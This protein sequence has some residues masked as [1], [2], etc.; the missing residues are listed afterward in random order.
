[1]YLCWVLPVKWTNLSFRRFKDNAARLQLFALAY[2][3]ANF[4]GINRWCR[5]RGPAEGHLGKIGLKSLL[6]REIASIGEGP[7]EGSAKTRPSTTFFA[8]IEV[9]RR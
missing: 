5:S 9:W 7:A 3:L 4:L 2:N 8:C 1:M 6:R